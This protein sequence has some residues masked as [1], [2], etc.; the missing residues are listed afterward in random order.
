MQS[1]VLADIL[2]AVVVPPGKGQ[3]KVLDYSNP[4]SFA[5]EEIQKGVKEVMGPEL[6]VLGNDPLISDI[7]NMFLYVS[8]KTEGMTSELY[9]SGN[10]IVYGG[11]KRITP[12]NS[13]NPAEVDKF[14]DFLT[15]VKRR[16][17]SLKMWNNQT[18]YPGYRD[19]VLD[20][21]II[22]TNVVVGQPEFQTSSE[23]RIQMYI[24]LMPNTQAPVQPAS[25][26]V[27]TG[28]NNLGGQTSMEFDEDAGEVSRGLSAGA[29]S[30]MK[31]KKEK[32]E[33]IKKIR[34]ISSTNT[35]TGKTDTVY[36]LP[37][38]RGVRIKDSATEAEIIKQIDDITA[39]KDQKNVVPSQPTQPLRKSRNFKNIPKRGKANKKKP[40]TDDSVN[41]STLKTD[42]QAKNKKDC[43]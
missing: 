18:S 9:M 11:G 14:L 17:L 19:F 33:A 10:H 24:G 4:L 34:G 42:S 5:S 43:K 37:T 3:K 39:G 31:D 40:N 2:M 20:N 1:K 29:L 13:K 12:E 22:N 8:G 15:N 41:D 38:F 26:P 36:Q 32:A 16:Q 25:S 23:R 28:T 27:V 21:K 7:V 35:K 30:K 6:A